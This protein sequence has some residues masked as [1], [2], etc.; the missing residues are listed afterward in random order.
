MEHPLNTLFHAVPQIGAR[1]YEMLYGVG[2]RTFRVEL[3]EESGPEASRVISLYQGL[4][5]QQQSG[6]TL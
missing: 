3:L 2:L 6:D 1:F 5:M 4:L